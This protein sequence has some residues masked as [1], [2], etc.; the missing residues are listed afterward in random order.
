MKREDFNVEYFSNFAGS[1]CGYIQC[2]TC[3]YQMDVCN[4]AVV[5]INE[6]FAC[7]CWNSASPSC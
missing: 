4:M 5:S 7:L 1:F 2:S 3:P 6:K